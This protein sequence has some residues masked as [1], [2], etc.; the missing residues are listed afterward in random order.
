M[1]NCSM[2]YKYAKCA[3]H[4][5][6]IE[7]CKCHNLGAQQDSQANFEGRLEKAL[8]HSCRSKQRSNEDTGRND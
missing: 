8:S 7:Y 6:A 4:N 5:S 2:S 1:I 3:L